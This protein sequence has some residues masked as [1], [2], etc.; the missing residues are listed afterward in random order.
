[1]RCVPLAEANRA[2][3]LSC[4]ATTGSRRTRFHASRAIVR[5]I[6]GV[7][8]TRSCTRGFESEAFHAAMRYPTV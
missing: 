4:G 6:P 3:S 2:A 8:T 1:M 5:P 7:E